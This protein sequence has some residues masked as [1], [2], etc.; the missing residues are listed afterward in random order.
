[1]A[2]V[3]YLLDVNVS[4][5]KA[6]DDGKNQSDEQFETLGPGPEGILIERPLSTSP[7]THPVNG[8][9]TPLDEDDEDET[10]EDLI[11]GDEDEL[12]GDEE[13]FDVEL[14]DELDE[15]DIDDDDLVIDADDDI[16]DDDL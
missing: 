12:S 9:N 10:E 6:M 15:E 11:L 3:F 7:D 13:E 14:E 1:L 16:E 2:R 4:M 8:N 5:R